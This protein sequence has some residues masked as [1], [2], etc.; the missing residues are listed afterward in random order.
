MCLNIIDDC[1]KY[2]FMYLFHREKKAYP[3]NLSRLGNAFVINNV[4]SLMPDSK[5]DVAVLQDMLDTVGFDVHI[6][7]DCD[8]KVIC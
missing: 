4:A 7:E 2:I 1:M 8:E 6:Y 3:M 5:K